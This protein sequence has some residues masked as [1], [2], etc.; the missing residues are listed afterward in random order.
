MITGNARR[1][2]VTVEVTVKEGTRNACGGGRGNGREYGVADKIVDM[3]R[4]SGR[5]P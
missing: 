5:A 2:E 3:R 4:V 1:D